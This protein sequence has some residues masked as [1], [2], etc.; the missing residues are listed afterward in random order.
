MAVGVAEIVN[1]LQKMVRKGGVLNLFAGFT[2]SPEPPIDVNA[3]HYSEIIVTGTSG[4]NAYH[5]MEALKLICS[6]QIDL[7]AL[8][9]HQLPLAEIFQGLEIVR[10]REGMRVLICPNG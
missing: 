4:S 10:R 6:K 8:I 2:G 5:T 9:S 7:T 3:I 1:D